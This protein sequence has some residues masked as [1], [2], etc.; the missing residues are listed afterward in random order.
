MGQSSCWWA[1][2]QADQL[3]WASGISENKRSCGT[4]AGGLWD[5]TLTTKQYEAD[6]SQ[7]SLLVKAGGFADL[8]IGGSER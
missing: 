7:M 8:G 1:V 4:R 3:C 5:M 2:C 6:T